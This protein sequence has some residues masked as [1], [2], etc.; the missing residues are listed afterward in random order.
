MLVVVGG[1]GEHSRHPYIEF[2]LT[3]ENSQK[4]ALHLAEQLQQSGLDCRFDF[5][6]QTVLTREGLELQQ[7][8]GATS[9]TALLNNP[10]FNRDLHLTTELTQFHVETLNE[11]REEVFTNMNGSIKTADLENIQRPTRREQI[12]SQDFKPRET[13]IDT[14]EQTNDREQ[15][16]TEESI[17]RGN[18]AGQQN[19]DRDNQTGQQ[20]ID[21]VVEQSQEMGIRADEI[22]DANREINQTQQQIE[23]PAIDNSMVLGG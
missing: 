23:Q 8:T 12:P 21:G 18:Q 9:T 13:E 17:N 5:K 6:S 2:N 4:L 16:V 15:T 22:S 14:Q 20:M 11:N 1:G 3:D 10:E 19:I 7:R